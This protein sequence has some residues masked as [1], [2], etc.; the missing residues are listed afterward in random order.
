VTSAAGA[1]SGA[2]S[3]TEERTMADRPTD[4][5][6]PGPERVPDV[7]FSERPPEA[8]GGPVGPSPHPGDYGASED[9]MRRTVGDLDPELRRALGDANDDDDGP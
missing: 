2:I 3:G 4:T 5:H 7:P 9:E 6:D 8:G 1:M